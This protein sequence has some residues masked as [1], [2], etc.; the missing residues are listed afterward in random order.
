MVVYLIAGNRLEASEFLAKV[1][2]PNCMV[3]N[4]VSAVVVGV[5]ASDDTNDGQVLAV[6]PGNGVEN[7]EPPDGEGD[8]T[9]T[10]S[11]SPGVAIGGIPGVELVAAA[12]VVQT[13]LFDEAVEKGEVEVAGN[14][15]DVL[16]ADLNQTV[17]DVAAEGGASGRT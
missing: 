11:T 9:C 8:D 7:A 4:S 5:G 15:E 2:Q 16:D 14:S 3:E 6:S 13:R 1:R 17:G 12:D 10:D